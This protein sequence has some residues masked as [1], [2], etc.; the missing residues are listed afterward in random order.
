MEEGDGTSAMNTYVESMDVD[1]GYPQEGDEIEPDCG[2]DESKNPL[3]PHKC[4]NDN[5]C[6]GFRYCSEW[7]WCHGQSGCDDK[8][9]EEDTFFV[10]RPNRWGRLLRDQTLTMLPPPSISI[11]I[12]TTLMNRIWG[13]IS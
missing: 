11:I 3:G 1:A 10:G 6:E 7:G 9:D 13:L 8:E 4:S 5:E 2:H 12:I